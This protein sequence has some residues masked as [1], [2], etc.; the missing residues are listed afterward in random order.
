MHDRKSN[1]KPDI[2]SPWEIRNSVEVRYS[3]VIE[4][5]GS[6]WHS[7]LDSLVVGQASSS[8]SDD[9]DFAKFHSKGAFQ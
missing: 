2:S 8:Q 1:L 3:T 4:F 6:R 5:V 7:H 9:G